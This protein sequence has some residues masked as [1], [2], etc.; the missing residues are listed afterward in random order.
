MHGT[1]QYSLSSHL[2]FISH[3]RNNN[4]TYNDYSTKKKKK[5]IKY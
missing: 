1:V 3:L 2:F 5:D 4:Q